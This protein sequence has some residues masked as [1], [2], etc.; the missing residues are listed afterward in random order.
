MP[1]PPAPSSQPIPQTPSRM[2]RSS[3]TVPA[4][5][6]TPRRTSRS[7]RPAPATL[8]TPHMPPPP[9]PSSRLIPQTSRSFQSATPPMHDPHPVTESLRLIPQKRSYE[10]VDALAAYPLPFRPI[11]P[12]Y[13]YSMPPMPYSPHMGPH[14]VPAMSYGAY[15][16]T[17]VGPSPS[18]AQA[19]G[20]S[21]PSPYTLPPYN[22][23]YFLPSIPGDPRSTD[24]QL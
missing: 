3:R 8:Q 23:N 12:H 15:V 2:S 20:S 19:S 17:P 21:A 5:P 9:A 6:Q 10:G 4:T 11:P 7:S 22:S 14:H 24:R 16:N 1:P 13:T 18:Q